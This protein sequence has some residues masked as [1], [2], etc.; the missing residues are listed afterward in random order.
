MTIARTFRD[1]FTL[2]ELLIVIVIIGLLV[3]ILLPALKGA[4][5]SAR[6]V[7]EMAMG[8]QLAVAY[9]AY[10]NDNK[11]HI[12]PGLLRPEEVDLGEAQDPL[13]PA[14]RGLVAVFDDKNRQI[15]NYS[16]ASRYPWRI[17][18]YVNNYDWRGMYMNR[19]RLSEFLAKP[20]DP[21]TEDM[22]S[23]HFA[24]SSSPTF[25]INDMSE[26]VLAACDGNVASACRTTAVRRT[27][28]IDFPSRVIIFASGRTADASA[29]P[30]IGGGPT[31]TKKVDGSYLVR[32]PRFVNMRNYYDQES[33]AWDPTRN[34]D[35]FGDLDLRHNKHAI[36][37]MFDGSV[38]RM[39]LIP[40]TRDQLRD[41]Q[42]WRNEANCPDWT[43][44]LDN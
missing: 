35:W 22:S 8:Q 27:D 32:P 26:S 43:G 2:V 23:R 5:E 41:M 6:A 19:E 4:R 20:E 37:V 36:T 7:A 31:V 3:A 39:T 1:A 15:T 34:A 14:K 21:A 13:Q 30:T 16:T 25:G 17:A 28:Q 42:H 33:V 18:P 40:G 12:L 11:T 29:G 9:H 24:L 10:A 44:I 38:S